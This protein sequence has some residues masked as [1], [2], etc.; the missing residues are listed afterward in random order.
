MAQLKELAP[1]L[2][3]IASFA[4][5]FA[6]V[7]G[8]LLGLVTGPIESDIRGLESEIQELRDDIARLE[9]GQD[10][11]RDTL[12]EA[13]EKSTT[14]TRAALGGHEHDPEGNVKITLNR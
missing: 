9:A 1:I 4:V 13:I 11:L 5:A 7:A 10:A 14:E 2:A 6:I 12:L 3:V 8:L